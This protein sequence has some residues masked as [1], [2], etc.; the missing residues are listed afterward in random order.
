AFGDQLDRQA[1]LDVVPSGRTRA[2]V[3]ERLAV[4]RVALARGREALAA[5]LPLEGDLL[6]ALV[7]QVALELVGG[8]L[9]V[10]MAALVD[11]DRDARDVDAGAPSRRPARV[12]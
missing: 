5:T 3:D 9:H 12:A 2:D 8:E 7:V 6:E 1:H 11:E 10:G 4:A